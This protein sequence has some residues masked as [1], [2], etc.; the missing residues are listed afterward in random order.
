VA[1]DA[2]AQSVVTVLL[3]NGDGTFQNAASYS[4]GT[5]PVSVTATDF[6]GDGKLDLAVAG[7]SDTLVF[8][9]GNGDGTFRAAG[10]YAVSGPITITPADFNGDGRVDLVV[11]GRMGNGSVLLGAASIL[12]I[13]S[14]H[15]GSFAAGQAGTYTLTV[16][17]DP[18]AA[19][20]SGLVTVTET[21]PAGLTLVS[22]TGTGWSCSASSCTRGDALAPGASYPP[23]TVMVNVSPSAPSQVINQ[24]SVSGGGSPPGSA[25]DPTSIVGLPSV[26]SGTPAAATATPQTFTFTA[27]HPNGYAQI[28]AIYFLVNTAPSIPQNTCHGLYLRGQNALYLY[29]DGLTAL[30]GPLTPGTS[31][32]LQNSQC[33]VYGSSSSLVSATGTDVTINL[34]LGLQTGYA[35][36]PQKVYLLVTDNQGHNSGWVQ[37][38]TW[39]IAAPNSPPAVVSGTPT[40]ATSTPQTFTFTG[41]D[42]DGYA[43]IGNIYFL[44]NTNATVSLNT[45][46]GLYNRAANALYLYSDG[47][48]AL[49]GPLTPGSS[50]TLQNSQCVVYGSSSSL[51]S[52][53]GTD[54]SINVRLGLQTG[55]AATP[56]NVYLWVKDNEGHSTGWVQSGTWDIAQLNHPPAVVSGTPASTSSTQQSFTFTARDVD[57]YA[58]IRYIYFLVNG[59]TSIPPNTCHGV[60]DRA[61]NALYLYNDGLTA[62]LGPLTPSTQGTLQNSQCTVYGM[63][64]WLQSG[65]GTDVIVAIGLGLRGSFAASAKNVYLW[66]KDNEGHDT[67]WVQTGIWNPPSNSP[68]VVSGI[69]ASAAG[70]PQVFVF[71]A[72]DADSYADIYRI[73][74][75]VN[76]NPSVPANTCH[77]LYDR[78]A[79]ALYLYSDGLT[80][81]LGPLTPGASGTLQNSQCTLYAS[82]SLLSEAGTDVTISI[83]LGLQP[84]YAATPQ[85]VYL[86]VKDNEGHG[87]GWVQTSTWTAQ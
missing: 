15:G 7:Q 61:A 84:G 35:A 85:N 86:W 80:A 55:Y 12:T 41:R 81:L 58:D 20:T 74:F 28:G 83:G 22:M 53:S 11:A 25:T 5:F 57:G 82:S 13:N 51:L 79:N 75:L 49:L 60:Y 54:I 48:T 65:S 24:V 62:V 3:G 39:S 46:H 29:N 44:V 59:D 38:G 40:S 78:A 71:T 16:A 43:D 56:Q 47:L 30:L 37:T 17:N 23:I 14:S 63:M 27:R 21:L 33:V 34:G 6:N 76:P 50:G 72:R 10:S 42:P 64:S 18:A 87:T 52:A 9:A 66:V 2:F 8:F 26:V 69:P 45:C 4:V 19:A 1:T 77:G 32:T 68:S 67:G 31:G 70:S 36:T 73:Y